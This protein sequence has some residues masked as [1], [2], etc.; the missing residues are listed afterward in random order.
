MLRVSALDRAVWRRTT[1]AGGGLLCSALVGVAFS[2][3]ASVLITRSVTRPVTQMRDLTKAMA[4]G[5]LSRRI[6][7]KQRDEVGELALATDTLADSLS[8]IVSEITGA[9]QNLAQ[10]LGKP[11]PDLHA[12]RV[13]E[14]PDLDAIRGRGRR[15]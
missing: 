12:A 13:A 15:G 3:L 1:R 2:I 10:L 14:R 5:D 6:G 9:S 7:L 11:R 8:R 4:A